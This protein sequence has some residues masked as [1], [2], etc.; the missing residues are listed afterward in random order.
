M[1]KIVI[2]AAIIVIVHGRNCG[3]NA[4]N[5]QYDNDITVSCTEDDHDKPLCQAM[6]RFYDVSKEL[7][8]DISNIKGNNFALDVKVC[9]FM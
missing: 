9:R 5:N 3:N 4:I 8:D 6:S 1:N 7:T 2:L